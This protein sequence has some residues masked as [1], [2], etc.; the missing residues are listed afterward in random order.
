MDCLL[1]LRTADASAVQQANSAMPLPFAMLFLHLQIRLT[2]DGID[3]GY[4]KVQ[5]KLA[6][7][8]SLGLLCIWLLVCLLAG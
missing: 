7:S 4:S 2:I 1:C 3:V 6:I 8:L 5:S